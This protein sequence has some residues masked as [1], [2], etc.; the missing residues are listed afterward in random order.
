MR[1]VE[2]PRR[3]SQRSVTRSGYRST[4]RL[5]GLGASFAYRASS[6]SR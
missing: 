1:I 6:M 5:N 2:A 4:Y 3:F